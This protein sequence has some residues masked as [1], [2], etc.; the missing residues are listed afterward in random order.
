MTKSANIDQIISNFTQIQDD[1]KSK[2]LSNINILKTKFYENYKKESIFI[3]NL[4]IDPLDLLINTY[5]LTS[6]ENIFLDFLEIK[7]NSNISENEFY[8]PDT[9]KMKLKLTSEEADEI[10]CQICNEPDSS[11]DNLIVL[12]SVL[13]E[14]IIIFYT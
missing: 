8:L 10:I 7:Q 14:K 13:Q 12:C 11:D 9:K 1:L 4:K 2:N 5:S 6:P 3:E